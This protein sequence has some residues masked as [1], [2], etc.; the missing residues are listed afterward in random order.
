LHPAQTITLI[1]MGLLLLL[2]ACFNYINT[3]IA[4]SNKRLKEIGI[5]KVVGSSRSGLVF[6]FMG[7]NFLI[8]FIALIVSLFIGTYLG[9]EYNKML[10]FD[11]FESNFMTNIRVWKFL[12]EIL[13]IT[14]LL[15]TAYPAF[16]ISS[17]NSLEILKGS[18]KFS[19]TDVFSR[20]L[21]IL[22]FSISLIGL[23]SSIAFAQNAG[24]QKNFDFGFNK[25]QIITIPAG[26]HSNIE[27]L[28][29]SVEK[30]P[31]VTATVTTSDHI[32]FTYTTK[33]SKYIDEYH[34][35][36]F[37][38]TYSNY[39][40]F[41]DIK[42]VDGREFT[43]EFESSD[44]NRSAIVNET[45]VKEFNWA[46]PIG[47]QIKIDS[48][49]LIVIGVVKD[50]YQ[51]LN[52]PIVP[53][54]MI[55]TPMEHLTR[56]LVKAKKNKLRSLNDQFKKQWERLIPYASYGGRINDLNYEYSQ[57]DNK[58][59]LTVFNFL[60]S[61]A[62]FLSMIALYTLVSLNI[63]KRTKEIGVRRVFWAP[64]HRINYLIVKPFFFILIIASI[65][66]GFGGLYLTQ[67]LLSSV[68]THHVNLKFSIV[69]I[70]VIT[71][72]IVALFTISAKVYYT[73]WKNPIKYLISE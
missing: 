23:V 26:S 52:A 37:L 67:M 61:V 10:S 29:E 64:S 46:N 35:V 47:K 49:N 69:L 44:L 66:G 22:Q 65:I 55:P 42:L 20:I 53:T 71:L 41:M 24:F 11:I 27:L 63:I 1:I 56:L 34:E 16:Y 54:V 72:V 14:T 38:N 51:N 57:I 2:L 19:G 62:I 25:D 17:F 4:V 8:C 30:N 68:W 31:D 73:L 70:P 33:I 48:L 21:L 58:N 6:Q 3:S 50:F 15:S 5:R 28:R 39:C 13:A 45:L 32:P 9:N 60:S 36:R 43:P 12:A 18:V 59:I 7:E 40:S